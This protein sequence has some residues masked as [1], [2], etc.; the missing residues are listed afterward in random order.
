MVY[1]NIGWARDPDPANVLV[2]N[3]WNTKAIIEI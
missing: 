1:E 3:C 2:V